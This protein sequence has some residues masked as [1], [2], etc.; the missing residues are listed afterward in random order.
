MTFYAEH[1]F[2]GGAPSHMLARKWSP[3]SPLYTHASFGPL[4]QW[5]ELR[6]FTPGRLPPPIHRE[7]EGITSKQIRSQRV[8]GETALLGWPAWAATTNTDALYPSVRRPHPNQLLALTPGTEWAFSLALPQSPSKHCQ[9]SPMLAHTPKLR[10][11]TTGVS[12]STAPWF[13]LRPHS[14]QSRQVYERLYGPGPGDADQLAASGNLT[15][16]KKVRA[17][18]AKLPPPP[19]VRRENAQR[20][21][22]A[23]MKRQSLQAT[24]RP[25]SAK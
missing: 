4:N 5:N 9:P 2:V 24:Q 25:M 13:R 11:E 10:A 16:A 23:A 22:Q 18:S 14:A 21:M 15:A 8:L 12:T 20:A 7:R 1:G 3:I 6:P 17:Q 19:A